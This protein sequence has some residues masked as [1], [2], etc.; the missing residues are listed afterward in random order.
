MVPTS[1]TV[2]LSHTF[3]V[4]A[5]GNLAFV[6]ETGAAI[7]NAAIASVDHTS[8]VVT[9]TAATGFTSRRGQDTVTILPVAAAL[10]VLTVTASSPGRL[11]RRPQRAA[12]PGGRCPAR[13][14]RRVRS[15]A[16]RSRRVTTAD[17]AV[18]AAAITVT[19]VPGTLDA[20]SAVPF[21][22]KVGGAISAVTAVAAAARG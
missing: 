9:L 5:G 12:A 7:G 8:K 4:A 14:R 1:T 10:N 22:I 19:P 20:A 6:S 13:P 18:G 15:A 21:S 2:T 3:G 17:A 11:G 16:T